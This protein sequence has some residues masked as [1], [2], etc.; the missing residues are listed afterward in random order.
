MGETIPRT[1]SADGQLAELLARRAGMLLLEIQR[2]AG[3]DLLGSTELRGSADLQAQEYLTASLRRKRP[4]DALLVP[5]VI[6]YPARLA[7]DRL[8]IVDPL[9][10]SA[11]FVEGRP[12][13]AVD[14]ALWEHGELRAG[15]LA[16]PGLGE[17]FGTS[18]PLE[19]PDRAPG[20]LRV[21]VSRT[22]PPALPPRVRQN[23]ELA[24]MGSVGYRIGA[25]L[26]GEVDAYVS[27]D[28]VSECSAAAG[29]ALAAAVG[30]HVS[31]WDGSELTFNTASA[32]L[33]HLLV[34]REEHA[35]WF[36]AAL[37]GRTGA[38]AP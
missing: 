4:S 33:A 26:R 13:F 35:T 10:G 36:V 1:A 22:R 21:A 27:A 20:P 2:D 8:W 18:A 32:E 15:A 12:D 31:H 11:E 7:A 19:V 3:T 16:L 37:S 23:V 29:I 28:P 38:G 14:V 25:V 5:G 6:D 17:V 30:L 9:D 24:P 34:C